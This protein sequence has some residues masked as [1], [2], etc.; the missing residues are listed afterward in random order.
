MLSV[1]RSSLEF[2]EMTNPNQLWEDVAILNALYEE[3]MW[4]NDDEL[5][6]IIE[7]NRIVIYNKSQEL[8]T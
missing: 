6:F 3:L 1:V 8:E 2:G 7:G 5:E 4:E